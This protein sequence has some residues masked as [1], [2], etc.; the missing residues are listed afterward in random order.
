MQ[1]PPVSPSPS[2]C[3]I[4]FSHILFF[5][6]KEREKQ[7]EWVKFFPPGFFSL[8][9]PVSS[10]RVCCNICSSWGLYVFTGITR[11]AQTLPS[12]TH[13]GDG[14]LN[15]FDPWP[16]PR[17][18]APFFFFMAGYEWTFLDQADCLPNNTSGALPP[19]TCGSRG[20][21]VLSH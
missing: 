15:C 19:L 18:A 8:F 17:S 6:S 14:P 9:F 5:V 12:E 2:R 7:E 10:S 21:L 1:S 13:G 4:C 3:Q 20:G 11:P 16:R